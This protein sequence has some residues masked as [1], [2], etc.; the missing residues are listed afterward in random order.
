MPTQMVIRGQPGVLAGLLGCI[1]GILGIFT[2]ALVFVPI[3]ALCALVGL[4]R[5]LTGGS[6]S[7]IGTSILAA[8]LC[9]FGFLASP[10]LWAITVAGVLASRPPAHTATGQ[11]AP[12]PVTARINALTQRLNAS[13]VQLNAQL[14][15]IGPVEQ[16]YRAIT[17]MMH[18]GLAQ[19]Q[20]IYGPAQAMVARNQIAVAISQAAVQSEQLHIGVNSA[21]SDIRGKLEPLLSDGARVNR[22]CRSVLI[23]L[24]S[25]EV[26]RSACKAFFDAANKFDQSTQAL[27][28]AFEKAEAVWV[29]ERRKQ[30]EIIRVAEATPR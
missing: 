23:D 25:S 13:S 27:S 10:S 15:K 29:E 26:D 11:P 6:I 19:Q 12:Q 5:G 28:S 3:A 20:S 16:R 7:G 8:I 30:E 18:G 22:H 24:N 4:I 17:G 14:G 2:L 21:Y 9:V 1:F